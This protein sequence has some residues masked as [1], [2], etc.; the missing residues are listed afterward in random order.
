M[1]AALHLRAA[2]VPLIDVRQFHAPYFPPA[3]GRGTV[4][5]LE[6]GVFWGTVGVVRELLARQVAD[7]AE[8]PWVVWTGG[9]AVIL[10]P[11]VGSEHARVEP[12]LVL[13]GLSHLDPPMHRDSH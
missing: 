13:I 11:H 2:Q 1:A 4:T 5:S 8:E 10:A 3:W 7:Q 6:A 9:D 12:D